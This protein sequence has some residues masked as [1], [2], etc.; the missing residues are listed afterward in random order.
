MIFFDFDGV[1]LESSNIKTQAFAKLFECL[2]HDN[3]EAILQHHRANAGISR[4]K[5]FDWIYESLLGERLS[6]AKREELGSR[7]SDIVLR[8]VLDAPS[9]AG[10]Q[11]A[12]EVLHDK[13]PLYLISGTP[14]NE[15]DYIVEER[16][17]RGYFQGL[18]GSP[19]TKPEVIREVLDAHGLQADQALCIGDGPSD[20][21]AALETGIHFLAR[22]TNEHHAFW[23]DVGAKTVPDLTDLEERIQNRNIE[24]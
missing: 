18:Y 10:A 7:F 8:Q 22:D 17:F 19:R 4:Y 6:P 1:I 2:S 5:K 15:L 23:V 3:V 13:M 21:R 11:E 12:M 14:Q 16:G 9:V 24:A 20:Y